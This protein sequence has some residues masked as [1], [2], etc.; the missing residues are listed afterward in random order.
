MLSPPWT[1]HAGSNEKKSNSLDQIPIRIPAVHTPQL[2]HGASPVY[3]FR[4]FENLTKYLI[5][6]TV[7][8]KI[9]GWMDMPAR[10]YPN[11]SSLPSSQNLLDRSLCDET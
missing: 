9:N 11:P 6:V 8:T 10:S 3:D 1:K 4:A 5:S 2:A 7:L